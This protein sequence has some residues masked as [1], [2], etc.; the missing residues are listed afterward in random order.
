[1]SCSTGFET[2]VLKKKKQLQSCSLTAAAFTC[3]KTDK[4]TQN[5]KAWIGVMV[6]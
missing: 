3:H 1:V 4:A 6:N 5:H 2:N